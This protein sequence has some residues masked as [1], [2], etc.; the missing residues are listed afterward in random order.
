MNYNITLLDNEGFMAMVMV[1]AIL[2]MVMMMKMT[3]TMMVLSMLS[4][5][6]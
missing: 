6:I 2:L 1:A 3:T 5:M 4:K